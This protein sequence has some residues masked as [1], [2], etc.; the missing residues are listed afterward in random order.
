MERT[1]QPTQQPSPTPP[2]SYAAQVLTVAARILDMH[3][4]A[5]ANPRLISQAYAIATDAILTTPPAAVTEDSAARAEDA[6]PS[7]DG[8]LCGEY[9]AHL[10]QIAKGL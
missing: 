2:P 8:Q 3:P 10:R 7:Y 6:M 5:F 9:A 1:D 4:D